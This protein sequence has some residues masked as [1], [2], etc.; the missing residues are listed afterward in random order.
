[1]TFATGYLDDIQLVS[2]GE[3]S[4]VNN[5]VLSAT[6][7]EDGLKIGRFA[8][9]DAGSIDN[10]DGSATPVIAGVVL[11]NVASAIED[12]AVITAANN[13]QIDYLRAGLCTVDVRAGQTPVMFGAVSADATTGEAITVGGESTSFEF[14]KEIKAGVWLVRGI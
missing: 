12:G 11:R 4:G 14:I 9:L 7:F 3:L 10:L 5:T 13:R 1:M 2:S 8:K 6:A